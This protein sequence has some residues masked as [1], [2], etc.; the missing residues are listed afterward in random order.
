MKQ[1]LLVATAWFLGYALGLG[2]DNS[3][4]TQE[5]LQTYL[6]CEQ[7]NLGFQGVCVVTKNGE[8]LYQGAFG[9][10]SMELGVNMK[11]D[12]RFRVASISKSFT[13]LLMRMA[14]EEGRVKLEG[15]L[16]SLL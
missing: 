2:Q 16:V 6:E 9:M 3:Q 1:I 12:H 8:L 10:A 11:P 15:K 14:A 7:E 4:Q 13:A 5:G